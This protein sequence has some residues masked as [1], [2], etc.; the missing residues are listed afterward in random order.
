M[1]SYYPIGTIVRLTIDEQ[2]LFMIAGYLPRQGD[3]ETRDYFGVPFPLG[4][5]KENQYILFDHKCI[6]EVIHPGYCDDECRKLLDGF[7]QFV[8]N[9]NKAASEN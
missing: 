2:R 1:S 8:E 7:D 6:T 5:M 3:G 4:L 9:I